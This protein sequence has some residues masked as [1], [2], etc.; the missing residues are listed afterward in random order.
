MHITLAVTIDVEEEGL[1]S[2]AYQAENVGVTNVKLLSLLDPVFREWDIRPTLLVTYPVAQDQSSRDVLCKLNDD[3]K[4]EIGAHL[5]HWNT[6]P[7]VDL[8]YKSPAPSEMMPQGLLRAK[9]KNL[10]DAVEGFSPR[11]LSFRMG[12]FN[13]GPKMFAVLSEAGVEVDSSVCP[14]HKF[15]GGPDHLAAPAEPYFPDPTNILAQGVSNILEAPVTV[16]GLL[17]RI[18]WVFR[19]LDTAG[20]LPERWVPWAASNLAS[21]PVQPMWTGP[22][23]LKAGVRLHKARGGK[24]IT[25]FF[26][27][28]EL[29][30]GGCPQHKTEHDVRRFIAKLD[31]FFLWINREYNTTPV[32]LSGLRTEHMAEAA[33]KKASEEPDAAA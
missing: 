17:P 29:M 26:H 11:P 16:P 30:P 28:S 18:G 7:L 2:G 14:L 22:R 1:F 8:P 27:S 5:H 9:L 33:R 15:Y 13:M 32:T 20:F 23:R 3:W 19:E 6:P 24:V 31:A 25:L 21:L 12:R 4:G 10:L